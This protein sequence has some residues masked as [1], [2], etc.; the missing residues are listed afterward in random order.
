[1]TIEL[2]CLILNRSVSHIIFLE[3]PVFQID[4]LLSH[5][6]MS[7]PAGMAADFEH[8]SFCN[9]KD[10]YNSVFLKTF[11]SGQYQAVLKVSILRP[12]IIFKG[13]TF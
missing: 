3:A 8:L 7:K 4:M 10:M 6:R 5:R 11:N 12:E 13:K 2:E 9:K 1:M